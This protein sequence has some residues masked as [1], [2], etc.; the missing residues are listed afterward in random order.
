MVDFGKSAATRQAS[1]EIDG[2]E[3]MAVADPVRGAEV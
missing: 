1:S 3:L 2:I